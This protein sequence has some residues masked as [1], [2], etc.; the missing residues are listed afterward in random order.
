VSAEILL[1]LFLLLVSPQETGRTSYYAPG[2]GHNAGKICCGGI[3]YT[4]TQIHI[5]YRR[6]W[7]YGCGRAVLIW[8]P[9]TRSIALTRIMD[10]GPFGI[11]TGN[12]RG[13]VK[14]G[15]WKV[16]TKTYPPDGWRWRAGLDMSV[17]LW[18]KMGRPRALTKYR[19]WILPFKL[20]AGESLVLDLPS[21]PVL[22]LNH[23]G[24]WVKN[25]KLLR[26]AAEAR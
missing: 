16:W 21:L 24:E 20:Q 8:V 9:Q 18:K 25:S 11:Y 14:D 12:L 23:L 6:W 1:A 13:A 7:K 2:D 4:T 26:G 10:A 5:A 3:Q 17:G 22:L 19:M 15:R